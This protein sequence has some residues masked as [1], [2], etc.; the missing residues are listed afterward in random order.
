MDTH[1]TTHV[2]RIREFSVNCGFLGEKGA[3]M[4]PSRSV[5]LWGMGVILVWGRWGESGQPRMGKLCH[6]GSKIIEGR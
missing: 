2:R 5:T 3:D 4:T 1:G 6:S